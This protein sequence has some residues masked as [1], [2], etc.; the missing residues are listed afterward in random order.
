[1]KQAR[2]QEGRVAPVADDRQ[3]E[4]LAALRQATAAY[5]RLRDS[6]EAERHYAKRLEGDVR[7]VA[8][9]RDEVRAREEKLRS[10]VEAAHARLEHERD[11]SR[12]IASELSAIH[13][14]LYGGNT[15][16]MLLRA[17]LRITT[18]ARGYYVSIPDFI[19]RAAAGVPAQVGEDA[20]PFVAALCSLVAE[21]GEPVQWNSDNPPRGMHPSPDESF[22]EGIAV[23]V[24]VHGRSHGV[25]VALDKA[26]GEFQPE[27][28]RSLV[29]IGGEAGIAVENAELRDE[30]QRAYLAT[31]SLLADTIEASDPY[32]RGHCDRV[33]EY[34]RET[35]LRLGVRDTELRVTCYAALLH[36]V[37]KI[38]VSDGVLNKPG[39]LLEEERSLMQAHVRIGYDLLKTIP[40][41]GGVADTVLH[42]HE[43]FDGSG[44]PDG[45]QGE[46]IPLPSRIVAAADAYCAMLDRRAYKD[47]MSPADA[48]AEL[49]RC[50]GT[51]FD[52]AVVKAMVAAIEH[53]D[54]G[55][56]EGD[57]GCGLLPGLSCPDTLAP[58]A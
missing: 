41:L 46:Q 8:Q 7:R 14:E 45:L 2:A 48:C 12:R 26:D 30:V 40:A 57:A 20:T 34:A 39:P 31:V 51:Q 3:D 11:R 28:V 52:P 58:H 22:R 42:H 29:S 50:A 17:S 15:T 25:I 1:M 38:G 35:A 5:G 9:E 55:L 54:A 13:H 44:Y 24:A 36:D 47:A 19:V 27:D 49:E 16:D 33:S 18:A 56:A 43:W 10:E 37:G 21:S 4:G 53:V 23:L 32:T 6:V